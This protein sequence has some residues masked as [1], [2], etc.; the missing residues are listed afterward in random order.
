MNTLTI[1]YNDPMFSKRFVDSLRDTGFAVIKQHPI[2]QDLINKV[3][4]DWDIFFKSDKKH[5]YVYDY[6]DCYDEEPVDHRLA[7]GS[8]YGK[9]KHRVKRN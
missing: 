7:R 6:D 5:D 9:V 4:M 8:L 1:D 2:N 3:Y